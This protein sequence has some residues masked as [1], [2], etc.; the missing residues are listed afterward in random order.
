MK[1]SPGGGYSMARKTKAAPQES[2]RRRRRISAW[3]KVILVAFVSVS[4]VSVTLVIRN[5]VHACD[6]FFTER[7]A[8]RN[9]EYDLAAKKQ[10]KH[11][12]V[13]NRK[14]LRSKSGAETESRKLG[15]VRPG[16]VSVIINDKDDSGKKSKK[17][18]QGTGD[19]EQ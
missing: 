4:I 13:E 7:A 10:K 15:Y 14:Y 1:A 16:E 18:E 17:K 2:R 8:V 5:I 11:S 19:R 12:L 6:L 3:Q 9:L